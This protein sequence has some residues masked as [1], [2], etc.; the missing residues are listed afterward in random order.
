[1]TTS[2]WSYL[3]DQS[4]IRSDIRSKTELNPEH[5]GLIGNCMM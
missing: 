5:F 2:V 3:Q 4:G 1:M